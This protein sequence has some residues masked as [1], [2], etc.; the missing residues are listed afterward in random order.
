MRRVCQAGWLEGK[1]LVRQALKCWL[2]EVNTTQSNTAQASKTSLQRAFV[3]QYTSDTISV[4]LIR[5]DHHG[6]PPCT[7]KLLLQRE[8]WTEVPSS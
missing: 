7:P 5:S 2:V 6:Q 8:S 3:N 1:T 4:D